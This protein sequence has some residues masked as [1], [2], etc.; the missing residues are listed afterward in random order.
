MLSLMRSKVVL[1]LICATN[2][3]RLM[4]VWFEVAVA[5][6]RKSACSANVFKSWSVVPLETPEA[7]SK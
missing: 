4:S 7:A 6:G 1:A 5:E 3:S 2:V